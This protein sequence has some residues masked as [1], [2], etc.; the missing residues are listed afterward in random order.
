MIQ[1]LVMKF[2]VRKPL[3]GRQ[4]CKKEFLDKCKNREMEEDEVLDKCA[5][6]DG[7]YY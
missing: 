5:N 2:G 7:K 4:S 1:E 3:F 6:I